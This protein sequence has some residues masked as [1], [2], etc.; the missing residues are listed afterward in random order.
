MSA[1]T[2]LF[3]GFLV[4]KPCKTAKIFNQLYVFPMSPALV[5]APFLVQKALK[6]VNSEKFVFSCQT[7]KVAPKPPS[8]LVFRQKPASGV[9]RS[10]IRFLPRKACE[11]QLAELV[12]VVTALSPLAFWVQKCA[13]PGPVPELLLCRVLRGLTARRGP[14]SV[15]DSVSDCK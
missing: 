6:T 10:E 14:G 13:K 15:S 3:I 2:H 12:A 11:F 8:S 4:S 1:Y 9:R 7:S 5:T